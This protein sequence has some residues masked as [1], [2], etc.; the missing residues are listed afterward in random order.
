MALCSLVAQTGKKDSKE[1]TVYYD[2]LLRTG[3]RP[4]NATHEL[5]MVSLSLLYEKLLCSIKVT[6]A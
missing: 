4:E 5:L 1:C 6:K 3:F 2:Q